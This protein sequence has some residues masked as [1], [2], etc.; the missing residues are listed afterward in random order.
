LA[1]AREIAREVADR[2]TRES[3]NNLSKARV[4]GNKGQKRVEPTKRGQTDLATGACSGNA[5]GSDAGI[6]LSQASLPSRDLPSVSQ[7]PKITSEHISGEGDGTAIAPSIPRSVKEASAG[8]F[9]NAL[10][11]KEGI[12][13]TQSIGSD[14]LVVRGNSSIAVLSASVLHKENGVGHSSNAQATLSSAP[15]TTEFNAPSGTISSSRL[16]PKPPVTQPLNLSYEASLHIPSG[17]LKS[18]H[19]THLQPVEDAPSV[20]SD[21]TTATRKSASS[22]SSASVASS[23]MKLRACHVCKSLIFSEYDGGIRCPACKNHFHRRCEPQ[24]T[25]TEIT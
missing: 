21:L 22:I 6:D 10:L 23:E 13:R 15:C 14:P 19:T 1:R 20:N 25:N 9:G 11:T 24:G 8:P 12:L 3:L 4:D 7:R 5:A 17:P 16:P 2:I 18:Q